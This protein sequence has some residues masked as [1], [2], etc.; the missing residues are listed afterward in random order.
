[1]VAMQIAVIL[2]AAG[3]SSRFGAGSKLD[4]DMGG[5]PVLQRTLELF[6]HR[7]EVKAVVVAGPHE[8]EAWNEFSLRHADKIGL[9]GGVVCRGGVR[10]RWETVRA[11]LEHVPEGCTHIAV[12]DAARPCT[13]PELIDRVFR[14]GA[15]HDA[16][17]PCVEITDTVKRLSPQGQ[18]KQEIDPLDAILG[19]GDARG[20][21]VRTVEA[22]VARERLALAQTPQLFSADLLRRAYAQENLDSTDDAGLVER[23]GEPVAVVEGDARNI[24]ITRPHDV[25]VAMAILGLR[26]PK[27][28][29]SHKK[30]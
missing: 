27:G 14:A 16:V 28:R 10:H 23:L 24:K 8:E 17:V 5:R 13:P 19:G 7:D 21:T 1:M 30:F 12:H 20:V 3:A 2:P 4:A 15:T 29:E 25:T 11:A 6:V 22:T 18:A 9:Y 26:A